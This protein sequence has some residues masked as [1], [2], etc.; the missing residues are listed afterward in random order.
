MLQIFA[1]WLR[2]KTVNS[3]TEFVVCFRFWMF[4]TKTD[5]IW[6]HREYI[7][8]HLLLLRIFGSVPNE[9]ILRKF[10]V[11]KFFH[12]SNTNFFIFPQ[13]NF[14]RNWRNFILLFIPNTN[15]KTESKDIRRFHKYRHSII[16]FGPP[17]LLKKSNFLC[18]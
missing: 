11:E 8:R 6:P 10:S 2:K 16:S 3:N 15:M 5:W 9:H 13:R 17:S 4:P 7:F 18:F 14:T 1:K 12:E